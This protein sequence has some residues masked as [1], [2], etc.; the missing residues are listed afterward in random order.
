[1]SITRST[2]SAKFHDDF[3]DGDATANPTWTSE[4]GSMSVSSQEF[5]PGAP[6]TTGFARAA[7]TINNSDYISSLAPAVAGD[8]V[9]QGRTVVERQ[10]DH[11]LN[12]RKGAS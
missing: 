11:T 3:A 1:M 12:A 8:R 2:C 7:V 10:W 4:S 5:H 6:N 9:V